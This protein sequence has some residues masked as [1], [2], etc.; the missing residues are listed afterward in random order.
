MYA[1]GFEHGGEFSPDRLVAAGI[2][3]LLPGI[4]THQD[5]FA[6]HGI[7]VVVVDGGYQGDATR[8]SRTQNEAHTMNDR[9]GELFGPRAG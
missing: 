5:S 3:F 9:D 2:F 1:M 7:R 6:D 4:H 8:A